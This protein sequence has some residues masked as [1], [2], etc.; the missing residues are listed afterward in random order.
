MK[1]LAASIKQT[2]ELM[3]GIHRAT[4]YRLINK[5]ELKAV[6]VGGRRLVTIGSIEARLAT[7]AVVARSV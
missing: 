1:P 5:G 2:G 7:G 6:R 3:G 4:V